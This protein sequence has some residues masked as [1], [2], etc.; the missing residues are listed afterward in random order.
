MRRH[1]RDVLAVEQ[2]AA[3]VRRLETGEHAQQRGLAAAAWAEQR[4]ELACADIQ[5]QPVHRAEIAELLADPL[6]PQQR[7]VDGRLDSRLGRLFGRQ[8]GRCRFGG[9]LGFRRLDI[10]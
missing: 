2:D 10:R 7:H 6:D 3:L 1:L 5:R 4:K 9:R 8:H